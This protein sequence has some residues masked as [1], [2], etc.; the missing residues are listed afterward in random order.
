[1]AMPP[2]HDLALFALTSG[3]GIGGLLMADAA[4]EARRG[5]PTM[6]RRRA[7]L[8]VPPSRIP[9]WARPAALHCASLGF[10][11]GMAAFGSVLLG[12]FP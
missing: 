6:R 8:L 2:P 7:A 1:M 4:D 3:C 5:V 12:A 10:L 9:I 11:G